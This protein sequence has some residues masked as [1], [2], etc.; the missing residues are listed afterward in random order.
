MAEQQNTRRWEHARPPETP[1]GSSRPE[2]GHH[3][4]LVAPTL[5]WV[6]T[7]PPLTTR[8]PPRAVAG[9]FGVWEHLFTLP[10]PSGLTFLEDD[11]LAQ[12]LGANGEVLLLAGGDDGLQVVIAFLWGSRAPRLGRGVTQPTQ[13][14]HAGF[15]APSSAMASHRAKP[16]LPPRSQTEPRRLPAHVGLRRVNPAAKKKRE[17]GTKSRVLSTAGPREAVS[18]RA[19]TASGLP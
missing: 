7:R 9:C 15:G 6:S 12:L 16:Q 4:L 18:H 14:S 10:P 5:L 3:Q 19:P 17:R 1:Q 8:S 2:P 11:G 13:G